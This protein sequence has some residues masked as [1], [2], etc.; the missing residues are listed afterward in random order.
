[1]KQPY[2]DY[3]DADR[4]AKNLKSEH[5]DAKV[6]GYYEGGRGSSGFKKLAGFLITLLILG[7]IAVAFIIATG[8]MDTVMKWLDSLG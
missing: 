7:A 4:I 1:M 2:D 5:A 8:N 6:K 3:R